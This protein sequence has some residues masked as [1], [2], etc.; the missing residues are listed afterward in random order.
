METRVQHSSNALKRILTTKEA[1]A[2]L[3]LSVS[4]F[5]QKLKSGVLPIK[6]VPYCNHRYDLQS[7][8]AYLDGLNCSSISETDSDSIVLRRLKN[9]G[10]H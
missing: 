9:R 6:A 4:S 5:A 1:A 7:I 2:R 3:G 8:D 10:Q